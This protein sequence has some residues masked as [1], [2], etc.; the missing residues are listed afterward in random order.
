MLTITFGFRTWMKVFHGLNA[1]KRNFRKK[2]IDSWQRGRFPPPPLWQLPSVQPE[3][4]GAKVLN[5]LIPAGTNKKEA[6]KIV[7][8]MLLGFYF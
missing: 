2:Y 7:A 6:A 3:N 1:E 4:C 5:R 8:S